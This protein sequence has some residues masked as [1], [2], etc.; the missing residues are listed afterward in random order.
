V[1]RPNTQE[2]IVIFENAGTNR[3]WYWYFKHTTPAGYHGPFKI[4]ALAEKDA[5][6]YN[7]K[8]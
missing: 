7:D 6:R 2:R 3:G 8:T 5:S 4:K 1:N